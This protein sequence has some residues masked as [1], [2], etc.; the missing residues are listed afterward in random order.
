[1][2]KIAFLLLCAVFSSSL[3]GQTKK[4]A[5]KPA[6]TSAKEA[7]SYYKIEN[8]VKTKVDPSIPFIIKMDDQGNPATNMEV[9]IEIAEWRKKHPYDLFRFLIHNVTKDKNFSLDKYMNFADPESAKL[10]STVKTQKFLLFYSKSEEYENHISM[11]YDLDKISTSMANDTLDF[12]ILGAYAGGTETYFDNSSQ[13]VKTRSKFG[14]Y[15]KLR[16]FTKL[17]I[18]FDPEYLTKVEAKTIRYQIDDNDDLEFTR[19][20]KMYPT[21][22]GLRK[23]W[24]ESFSKSK[25]E[26]TSAKKFIT[27]YLDTKLE[28]LRKNTDNV[29]YIKEVSAFMKTASCFDFT[30]VSQEDKKVMDKLIK[31][32]SMSLDDI[33]KLFPVMNPDH[34]VPNCDYG[35]LLPK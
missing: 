29:S 6:T 19:E 16:P 35:A 5:A 10:L 22:L 11:L 34:P 2:K 26:M 24:I 15:T 14:E 12:R 31:K 8:G 18:K 3:F 7:I 17:V 13:S 1:M 25:D 28:E 21:I 23:Q 27:T 32:S 9:V 30:N 33:F 4:P 20:N